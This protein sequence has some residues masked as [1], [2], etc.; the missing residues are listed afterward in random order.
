METHSSIKESFIINN[1]KKKKYKIKIF[2]CSNTRIFTDNLYNVSFIKD[3]KLIK[4]I[5][6][7]YTHDG[8]YKKKIE[9]SV[10]KNGT[11]KFI[12]FL[13]GKTLCLAQG[14]SGKNYFHWLFDIFP[15]IFLIRKKF[16]INH[17]DNFYLNEINQNILEDFLNI[18][19]IKKEKVVLSKKYK[20][21]MCENLIIIEH[22]YFKEGHWWKSFSKMPS[23]IVHLLKKSFVKKKYRQNK[24]IFIDRSD[25]KNP[26][27][28][29]INSLQIKNFLK[30][31]GYNVYNLSNMKFKNQVR[32]FTQASHIIAAH[33]AS[34]A[35]IT[36]CQKKTK[37]LDLKCENFKKNLLYKRISSISKLK[38]FSITFKGKNK[39][40]MIINQKKFNKFLLSTKFLD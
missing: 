24:K 13:P 26:H 10:L 36:F 29:I 20:H 1:L 28:R 18:L 3:N 23:W 12:K 33:G 39:N 35:N 16:N 5:S 27:N 17:F 4:K 22:P 14:A 21:V 11:P 34:L 31:K 6:F 25:T 9:N 40:N 32:L 38:Y 19:G 15:K 37:I 8:Y 30:K 7:E 2:Q